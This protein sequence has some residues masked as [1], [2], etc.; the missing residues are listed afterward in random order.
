MNV[1]SILSVRNRLARTGAIIAG[2]QATVYVNGG[3]YDSCNGYYTIGSLGT[4]ANIYIDGNAEVISRS[5]N[6]YEIGPA[7]RN[8]TMDS[9]KT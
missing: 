5:E 9:W 2:G 4:G 6:G 1:D 8:E 7:F 3:R